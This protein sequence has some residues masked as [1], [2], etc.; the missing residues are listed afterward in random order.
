VRKL[1]WVPLIVVLALVASG[2]SRKTD[3]S[4]GGGAASSSTTAAAQP[5]AFG[6]LGQVCGPGEA[7][8][9]TALGV[10]DTD[11]RV[12]T[13]ADPGFTATPG[14]DQEFF[15]TAKAFSQWCN[16]AGGI[17]GRQIRVDYL[18]AKILE[19]TD[20]IREACAQDFSLVGGGG[21]FDDTGAQQR[22][23]CGLIDIAGYTVNTQAAMA[24]LMIQPI[25][26]PV[27]SQQMGAYQY[28]LPQ[29]PA[30]AD[31]IG[32]M[33]G[34]FG[35]IKVSG[36]K[37]RTAFENLGAKIVYDGEYNVNG[38]A[39]WAPFVTTMKSAGVKLL[40][41]VGQYNNLVGLQKAMGDQNWFPTLTYV[42]PSFYDQSYIQTGGAT[43]KSTY[44]EIYF[45]PFEQADK[46]PAVQQYLDILAAS[47]P[48]AKP[49]MLGMQ[50]WSAWLMFA[51][52][53][54]ACG[55]NLTRDCL[56]S[57]AAKLADWTGGGL[58]AK[59]QPATNQMP[60]CVAVIQ[61]TQTGFT[62]IDP[63]ADGGFTCSPN[64]VVSVSVDAPPGAKK[65]TG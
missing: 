52:A 8:G 59:S 60:D 46:Y 10:S 56:M 64:N 21:V 65:T 6:D 61:A 45:H 26:N 19:Y 36:L 50:G 42:P 48:K 18:D 5:G 1:G 37:V 4:S 35:A 2:C 62:Q 43:A 17:A 13:I 28:L 11:I 53:A 12:G 40:Y 7:K 44:M 29:N 22:V 51:K 24:D 32:M 25:P 15:D 33:E 54:T 39:N 30:V 3:S 14:L 63:G 20:R 41:F 27:T 57:E 16:A 31:G 9:A 23:D 38:E 58:H 34:N 49:A 47:G 55:S